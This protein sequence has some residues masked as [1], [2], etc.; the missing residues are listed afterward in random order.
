[1]QRAADDK[2]KELIKKILTLSIILLFFGLFYVV[3]YYRDPF[4]DDIL[5]FY[6]H[7]I[8]YYLDK[9]PFDLGV[10]TTSFAQVITQVAYVY[11]VWTG[12]IIGYVIMLSCGLL[13]GGA[14]SFITASWFSIAAILC[15]LLIYGD[16]KKAMRII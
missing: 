15:A 8:S 2:K 14:R 13:S 11:N 9:I 16:W 10:R 1:M 4:G 5:I 7:G 3:Y 12:R 6:N